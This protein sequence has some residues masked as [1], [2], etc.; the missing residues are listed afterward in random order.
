MKDLYEYTSY[1]EYLHDYFEENK[2]NVKHFSHQFFAS[3]AGIKSTGFVLHVIKGERNLTKEVLLKI[4]RALGFDAVHT[5]YFEDLVA[6]DQAKTPS[7]KEHFFKRLIKKRSTAKVHSLDDQQ[8]KLYSEWYHAILRE[9]VPMIKGVPDEKLIAKSLM[10]SITPAQVRK[11]L[12]LQTE[13]GI[14][15]KKPNG[16][17]EQTEQFIESGGPVRNLALVNY[18]KEMLRQTLE[19]WDRFKSPEIMMNTIH[20][21]MSEERMEKVKEEVRKFKKT[22]FDI[23]A[24]DPKAP[25]RVYHMNL[26]LFPVTKRMDTV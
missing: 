25:E 22:L 13:L 7:D 3:K 8:Y 10:P 18:Q 16:E 23:L 12:R 6:F 4:S 15:R 20:F 19:A 11:S 26:N 5:E 24:T 1:R 9:L 14:L 2:K 21:T 17:Y